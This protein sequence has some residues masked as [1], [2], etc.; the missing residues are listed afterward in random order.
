M[1]VIALAEPATLALS[2]HTNR[3]SVETPVR[4][5]FASILSYIPDILHETEGVLNLTSIALE[6]FPYT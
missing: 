5:T 3:E 6:T 1:P 4:Q 2:S